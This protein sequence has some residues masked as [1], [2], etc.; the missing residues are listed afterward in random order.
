M[1]KIPKKTSFSPGGG[2]KKEET[3]STKKPDWK[4][5][6]PGCGKSATKKTWLWS[7]LPKVRTWPC[8]SITGLKW[9]SAKFPTRKWKIL[10]NR[11]ATRSTSWKTPSKIWTAKVC[12]KKSSSAMTPNINCCPTRAA[13]FRPLTPLPAT[14][15]KFRSTVFPA[16]T[17]TW[18]STTKKKLNG[19]VVRPFW[20]ARKKPTA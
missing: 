6:V 20:T 2:N 9:D 10:P 4:R 11:W 1:N 12:W 3:K 15:R 13:L 8:R 14:A 5:S 18:L 7:K 16:K 17:V 19:S